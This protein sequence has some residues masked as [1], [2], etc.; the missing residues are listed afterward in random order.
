M[1][2]SSAVGR[3]FDPAT[4]PTT[5]EFRSAHFAFNEAVRDPRFC[6]RSRDARLVSIQSRGECV[7]PDDTHNDYCLAMYYGANVCCRTIYIQRAACVLYSE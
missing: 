7:G 2:R 1:I 3:A 6:E 5:T 4:S